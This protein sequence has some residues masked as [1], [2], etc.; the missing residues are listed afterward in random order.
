MEIKS[1]KYFWNEQ[2]IFSTY[3]KFLISSKQHLRFQKVHFLMEHLHKHMKYNN[4]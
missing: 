2:N 4:L 3:V 1:F